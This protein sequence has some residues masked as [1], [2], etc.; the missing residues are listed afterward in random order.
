MNIAGLLAFALASAFAGAT[1]HV[2]LVEQ[3]ARLA[4]DDRAMMN[5]WRPSDHRGF[6]LFALLSLLSSLAAL[7][8]FRADGDIRW[9]IG[10]IMMIASWPYVFFVI[11]P[12]D[13]RLRAMPQGGEGPDARVL[14]RDWGLLQWGLGVIGLVSASVFGWALG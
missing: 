7:A 5:E 8:G 3:P 10:A 11:L 13:A 14:L 4:L 1:L 9:L 6:V 2:A 12:L